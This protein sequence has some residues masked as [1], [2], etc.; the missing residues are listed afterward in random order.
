KYSAMSESKQIETSLDLYEQVHPGFKKQFERAAT[1][2]WLNDPYARGAYMVTLPGQFRTVVP[3]LATTEGRI[4]FAGE[5]TSPWPGWMAVRTPA[6]FAAKT[7][8]FTPPMGSTLPLRVTSPVMAV[9]GR[10]GR[11][12]SNDTSAVVMVM[13]AEGPSF[14]M[15]PAGTWMWRSWELKNSS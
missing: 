13:P 8:S 10:T 2:S 4:H 1:W 11:S 15:A 6:R 14:G 12:V 3:Y 5:H 9:Y 7:F